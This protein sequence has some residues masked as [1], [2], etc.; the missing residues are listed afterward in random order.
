[1]STSILSSTSNAEDSATLSASTA[2]AADI[3]VVTEA[4][5]PVAGILTPALVQLLL[6]NNNGQTFVVADARRHG[7]GAGQT[8]FERFVLSDYAAL[9]VPQNTVFST[10][11]ATY[12]PSNVNKTSD[13]PWTNFMLRF[14]SNTGNPVTVSAV[15]DGGA[16][17]GGGA[18]TLTGAVTGTG[19]GTVPT[20]WGNSDLVLPTAAPPRRISGPIWTLTGAATPFTST[21]QGSIL[22]GATANGTLTIPANALSAGQALRIYLSGEFG[23]TVSQPAL[24]TFVLIGGVV[25]GQTTATVFAATAVTNGYFM[26]NVPITVLFPAVG[27]SG[28]AFCSGNFLWINNSPASNAGPTTVLQGALAT[29]GA[30]TAINT[31]N[32]LPIDVQAKWGTANAANTVTVTASFVEI[33]G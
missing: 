18:V 4:V 31:T 8:T 10:T 13:P 32:S 1:M 28:G 22:T 17:S 21:T 15:Y 14:A 11:S 3:V 6:S 19:T 30:L 5:N 27:A 29:S 16:S 24:Q 9:K 23:C 26:T 7:A 33:L 25:V 20:V 12:L 2:W